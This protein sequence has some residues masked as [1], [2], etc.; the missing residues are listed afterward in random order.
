[1]NIKRTYRCIALLLC[2]V[3]LFSACANPGDLDDGGDT[4]SSTASA[5]L[6]VSHTQTGTAYRKIT[7]ARA[8]EMMSEERAYILLDCRTQEEFFEQRIDGAILIPDYEIEL[9]APAEL[10]D[11]QALILIYCR[12]GRRSAIA[13]QLMIAMGYTNIY[14]FGGIID[15]PYGTT[16]GK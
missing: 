13:A 7:A 9:R 12:S 15:W 2:P 3:L 6:S 4:T 11:K 5:A 10:P 14:D 16:S 8:R 1:M